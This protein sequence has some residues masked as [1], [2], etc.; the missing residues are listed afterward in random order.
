MVKNPTVYMQDP[1]TRQHVAL[2]N[3]SDVT[4]KF[5]QPV[6]PPLKLSVSAYRSIWFYVMHGFSWAKICA[7]YT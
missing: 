5:I 6:F 7:V 2:C 1:V 3:A 4:V